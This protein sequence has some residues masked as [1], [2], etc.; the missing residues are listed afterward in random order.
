MASIIWSSL[1]FLAQL[2]TPRSTSASQAHAGNL[3]RLSVPILCRPD[4]AHALLQ[5]K[6]SFSF[7]T[8]TTTLSSWQ[9]GTDCCFWEGVGCDA[10]SG[11]ITVLDLNNRGLSSYGL[12]PAIF[13]LTS[14]RRLDL[15]MNY[16]FSNWNNNIPAPGFERFALL[17]HLNL[18]N[19]GIQGPVS[20]GIDKL[21]NLLSLDISTSIDTSID[22]EENYVYHINNLYESNFDTLVANLSSLRELYLDGADLS[23]SKEEFYISLATSVPRLQVLSLAFCGLE[24][25]VHKSL[26][27]LHSLMVINLQGNGITVVSAIGSL[28]DLQTLKM[29]LCTTYGSIL[30]SFG[31]LT[32]MINMQIHSPG[33][34]PMPTAIGNLTNLQMMVI[35]CDDPGGYTSG[36]IPYTIGQLNNLRLLALNGCYS[37]RIPNSVANLT[38]LTQMYLSNNAFNGEIPSSIFSIPVRNLHLSFNQ[39]SGPIPEFNEALSQLEYVRLSY[40]EFSGPIPKTFFQLTNLI[41]LDLRSNNLIGLV[42]PSS[43][44]KLRNIEIL[45]LSNNKLS[46]VDT[47]GSSPLPS[48]W[49]G[50]P[51]IGLAFCNITRFPRS[52][53]HSKYILYLDLSCNKISGDIPKQV[54]EICSSTIFYLN[55]SHNMFTSIGLTSDVLPFT[56]VPAI[57]DLSFN[58]LQGQIPMPNSSAYALDYSNNRFSSIHPNWVSY[59]SQTRYLIMSNNNISGFIPLSICDSSLGLLVLT[60]N[61]FSGPIPSCLIENGHL[62][63]LNLRDNHFEG[64]LSSNITSG[65]SSKT[66]DLHGNK[67]HGQLPRGLSNCQKLEV[68]D[69]GSNQIVDVFPSWLRGLS[70]LSVIVLR[71][72]KFYGTIG[73]TVDDT[74]DKESFPSL[75]II[76]LASNSFSGK[77]RPQWIERLKSMMKKFNGTGKTFSALNTSIPNGLYQYST[78]ITY[79]GSVVTFERILTTLKSIDFSNNRLEGTIPESLGRLVSLRVL[80]MSHNALTGKIPAKLGD[81][82]LESLD[83][84][85]N[86]LSGQIPEELTNLP[87]VDVLNLSNNDLVGKIPQARQFSTFDSSSFEGNSGLCG[88]PLSESP[89]GASAFSP[90][91]YSPNVDVV[92]FLF[93]GLGFGVGFAAAIVVKWGRI[94]RWF[95]VTARASRT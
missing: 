77:L 71:S 92:L 11:N 19:L 9:D 37:G 43:F 73:D 81:T 21:V 80:N 6:K 30:S 82:D 41:Q 47:E 26:S 44:W 74:E 15:S 49:S 90:G 67:I 38:Q 51:E 1:L 12:H 68:L 46:V 78:E 4:Q 53:T 54:W 22:F 59:L 33:S 63:V 87:F 3:T 70:E 93:V 83:L 56:T 32:N 10:S 20:I 16:F 76:D 2:H 50:P 79:K 42:D 69:F 86:Q 89:C 28:L 60:N 40:N 8:S 72:N 14:L 25:P 36:T 85:C 61:N 91:V 84:S 39:L 13:N 48:D 58:R 55:I 52:L 35:Q 18:S 94:G 17:T 24:G 31:N 66:I 45:H 88:P 7:S 29:T 5:L 62:E 34:V 27:R 57:L 64:M 23:R 65:C 95:N 75:Q